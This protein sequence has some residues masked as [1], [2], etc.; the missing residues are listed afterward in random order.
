MK[1][2]LFDSTDVRVV[3]IQRE[4]RVADNVLFISFYVVD[5]MLCFQELLYC[6]LNHNFYRIAYLKRKV[7]RFVWDHILI[8]NV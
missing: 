3:I 1:K 2:Y 5:R 7:F 8:S 6:F 4:L